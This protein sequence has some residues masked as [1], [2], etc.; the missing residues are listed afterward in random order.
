MNDTGFIAPDGARRSAQYISA[1]RQRAYRQMIADAAAAEAA[2]AMLEDRAM[3]AGT[4]EQRLDLLSGAAAHLIGGEATRQ[5]RAARRRS[6]SRPGAAA[7][8]APKTVPGYYAD[9]EMTL[10]RRVM[11]H[12]ESETR[13]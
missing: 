9:D 6:R 11:S 13:K 5:V 2:L 4:A 3:R 1:M 10:A 8:A 7:R 12:R